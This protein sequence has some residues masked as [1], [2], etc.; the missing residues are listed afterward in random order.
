MEDTLD[1]RWR[2]HLNIHDRHSMA[3]MAARGT[4]SV[5]REIREAAA[6]AKRPAPG[7]VGDRYRGIQS[8]QRRRQL[9]Q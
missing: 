7:V 2:N 3:L 4:V 1:F 9:A 5:E 6:F 8:R